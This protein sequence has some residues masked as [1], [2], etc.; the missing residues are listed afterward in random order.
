MIKA[1]IAARALRDLGTVTDEN[2]KDYKL[3]DAKQTLT[4]TF[5]DGAHTF[6]IGG[7][8]YGDSNRYVID[9]A[10]QKAYVL[11]K[12]LISGLEIGESNLHLVDPRGFDATKI[13]AVKIEAGD[14][15]KNAARLQT[16]VEGQQVKTWGDADTGKAD[17]TLANF[18]DNVNNL[19]P[20]EYQPATKVA[21]LTS[22]LK[23]TYRDDRGNTLGSLALYKHDKPPAADKPDAK[24]ETE[25]FVV[26]E[27]TRV[28]GL[29]RKDTAAR[30]ENDI[31]TV[32][33]E[34]PTEPTGSGGPPVHFNPGKLVPS[35]PV[36]QRPPGGAPPGHP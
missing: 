19:K 24:P 27:K 36:P 14:K 28:P 22:V 32:F 20:T 8:V 30:A 18:I 3:T 35:P 12:D 21:D 34:H 7:S 6:L 29:V 25:Y 2:K 9:Q 13:E 26:T 23:L 31:A 5:K 17:Q 1:V 11:S 10:T 16:G 4:I 33:G 15:V